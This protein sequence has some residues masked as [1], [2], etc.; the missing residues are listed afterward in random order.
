MPSLFPIAKHMKSY[1]HRCSRTVMKTRPR[2]DRADALTLRE[3][4][5]SLQLTTN[6]ESMGRFETP[7]ERL[8]AFQKAELVDNQNSPSL[9]HSSTHSQDETIYNHLVIVINNATS[10]STS[11]IPSIHTLA[12]LDHLFCRPEKVSVTVTD[13]LQQD[14][15][16]GEPL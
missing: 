5:F 6:P 12:L 1:A 8:K 7:Q 3:H 10:A 11:F 16:L 14:A 4:A 15:L 2:A 13:G 9:V